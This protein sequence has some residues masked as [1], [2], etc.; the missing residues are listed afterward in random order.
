MRQNLGFDVE[1]PLAFNDAFTYR[2]EATFPQHDSLLAQEAVARATEFC[3]V[4][5][6]MTHGSPSAKF[7]ASRPNDRVI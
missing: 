1:L 2:H 3:S 6:L 7:C 4:A 5:S